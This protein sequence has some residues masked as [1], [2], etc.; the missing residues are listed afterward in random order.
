MVG[1]FPFLFSFAMIK[2]KLKDEKLPWM[3]TMDSVQN[4]SRVVNGQTVDLEGI[5]EPSDVVVLE[6][7][8][9]E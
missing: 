9:R 1:R 7:L 8:Q 4:W 6:T 5:I 3:H 2:N